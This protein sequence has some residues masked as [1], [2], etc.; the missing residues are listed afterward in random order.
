VNESDS[1]QQPLRDRR[2]KARQR[3]QRRREAQQAAANAAQQ[4]ASTVAQTSTE[5]GNSL[6][7]IRNIRDWRDLIGM[8]PQL[9]WTWGVILAA[10]VGVIVLVAWITSAS[11]RQP[12][13]TPVPAT[14]TL[15][16]FAVPVIQSTPD[17]AALNVKEWDGKERVTI[18]IMGLDKRPGEDGTGFRT[19]SL[20]LLS[21]DPATKTIGM[22]SIPRDLYVP[23]PNKPELYA[24]NTAYV[25]GE[26]ERPGGGPKLAMQTV[27]YNLGIPIHYFAAV[28]FQ[29]VIGLVDSVGGVDINV[30]SEINDPEYPSMD[31]GYEPLKIPAGVVH[32][33]GSLALKYARTRHQSSDYDRAS[34]QQAVLL[35]VRQ[36]AL[37]SDVLPSLIGKAPD[38]W[39]QLSKNV[40]TDLT[41]DKLVSLGWYAKDIPVENIRRG[42]LRDDYLQAIQY[43][44][45]TV[46]TPN[47]AKLI[48]L[49]SQVFGTDYGK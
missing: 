42:A 32:M 41:F 37:K 3:T 2:G 29:A 5:A 44:G 33:D 17:F 25:I 48:E 49:M 8:H 38:I 22:L 28:S 18:L 36:K 35:A 13:S 15:P 46:V 43:N 31:Y 45:Q 30:P 12:E 39:N 16:A 7:T 10:T 9:N 14:P 19:D 26:L 24:I 11:S 1:P 47:R 20:I 27:Q 21:L 40:I 23:L 4:L 34:R 6:R